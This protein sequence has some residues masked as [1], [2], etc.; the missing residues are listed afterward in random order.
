MSYVHMSEIPI[1]LPKTN[2]PLTFS[3][4]VRLEDFLNEDDDKT[5]QNTP[6]KNK[7][8]GNDSYNNDKNIISKN[9]QEFGHRKRIK[10]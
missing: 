5:T 7:Y 6:N 8:N 4:R 10:P 3:R 2:I 1:A 9:Q